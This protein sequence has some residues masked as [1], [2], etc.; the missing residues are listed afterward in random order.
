MC[1]LYSNIIYIISYYSEKTNNFSFFGKLSFC[2]SQ[3]AFLHRFL[4]SISYL[5][6]DFQRFSMLFAVFFSLLT[7]DFGNAIVLSL[8][9]K[10]NKN[11][12]KA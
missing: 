1:A 7:G 6:C 8:T 12:Y 4:C 5:P 3:F 2:T 10:E 11:R 9:I